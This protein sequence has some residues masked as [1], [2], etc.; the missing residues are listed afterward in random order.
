MS[1]MTVHPFPF[2]LNVNISANDQKENFPH[3]HLAKACQE[4]KRG[5]A[6]AV[7]NMSKMIRP[8]QGCLVFPFH[9]WAEI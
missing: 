4:L 1:R 7:S 2:C 8:L 6:S 5:F 9:L 3:P